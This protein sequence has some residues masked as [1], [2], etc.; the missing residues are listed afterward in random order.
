M[1]IFLMV[2]LLGA[3]A[4]LLTKH[5]AFAMLSRRPARSAEVIPGLL[6]LTLSTN[7]GIVFGIQV[8][9]VLILTATLVALAIVAFLFATSPSRSWA[10]HS[11]LAMVLAGSVGNAYDRLF[12]R[13]WLP[14]ETVPRV[15]EVRDFIDVDLQFMRWPVFNVADVLLVVGVSVILIHMMRSGRRKQP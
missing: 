13:V 15:H 6:W 14:G 12:A 3:A 8:P 10:L 7:R 4:D 9:G 1:T 11:G 2:T 5:Y